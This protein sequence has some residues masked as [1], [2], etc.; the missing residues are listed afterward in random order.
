LLSGLEKDE[1][2]LEG[3]NGRAFFEQQNTQEGIFR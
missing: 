1:V 2:R 3:V